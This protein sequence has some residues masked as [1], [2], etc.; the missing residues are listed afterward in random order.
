M[1]LYHLSV[2]SHAVA[3]AHIEEPE[4]FTTIHNYALGLWV[5]GR[6]QKGGKLADVSLGQIFPCGKKRN[7]NGVRSYFQLHRG[8]LA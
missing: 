6:K 5:G 2:S 4:E 1:E 8:S 7:E 3:V